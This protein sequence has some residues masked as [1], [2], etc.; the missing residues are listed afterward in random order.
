MPSGSAYWSPQSLFRENRLM[1]A[2]DDSGGQTLNQMPEL[3]SEG[4]SRRSWRVATASEAGF[5]ARGVSVRR[6]LFGSIHVPAL[7][8]EHTGQRPCGNGLVAPPRPPWAGRWAPG[9]FLQLL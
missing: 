2:S 8:P 6:A 7:P 9:R 3:R 4:S 1:E 5:R